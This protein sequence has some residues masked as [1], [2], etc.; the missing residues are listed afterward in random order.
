MSISGARHAAP[1][2]PTHGSSFKEGYKLWS[3]TAVDSIDRC[4]LSQEVGAYQHV[5]MY[6]RV[7]MDAAVMV[8]VAPGMK[9]S[10]DTTLIRSTTWS[11]RTWSTLLLLLLSMCLLPNT[12]LKVHLAW[13]TPMTCAGSTRYPFWRSDNNRAAK[14][15]QHSSSTSI[16]AKSSSLHLLLLYEIEFVC[17]SR[18][19]LFAGE[20]KSGGTR[21]HD[22]DVPARCTRVRAGADH[23][24]TYAVSMN[25]KKK[26]DCIHHLH[27][28]TVTTA[29]S[30][31]YLS[32]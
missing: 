5:C 27:G 25:K 31:P 10:T 32:A 8:L 17:P 18:F 30:N 6:H 29:V 22:D 11:L 21:R 15:V 13:Y 26:R 28:V 16:G 20:K 2:A 7:Q 3:T 12:Y 14:R 1:S 23:S 24:Y 9:R 4:V 19:P